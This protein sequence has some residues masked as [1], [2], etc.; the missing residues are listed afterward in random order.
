MHEALFSIKILLDQFKVGLRK[1][2]MLNLIQSFPV[3]FA[4][5]FTFTGEIS[6]NDIVRALCPGSGN[7]DAIAMQFLKQ[8]ICSL[9][10]EGIYIFVSL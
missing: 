3:A 10:Q 5:L 2:N 4:P 8:Y 1:V 7:E 6:A 9:S